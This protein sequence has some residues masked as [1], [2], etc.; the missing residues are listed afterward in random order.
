MVQ[1]GSGQ[2]CAHQTG[3]GLRS[4]QVPAGFGSSKVLFTVTWTTLQCSPFIS[5]GCSMLGCCKGAC[6]RYQCQLIV[7]LPMETRRVNQLEAPL[8]CCLTCHVSYG[9]SSRY[10]GIQEMAVRIFL[11]NTCKDLSLFAIIHKNLLGTLQGHDR[12]EHN[13]VMTKLTSGGCHVVALRQR[14]HRNVWAGASV[15]VEQA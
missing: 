11:C 8:Q 10:C 7:C 15:K 5:T 13:L 1:L 4:D 3:L 14:V 12:P 2:R 9:V 6:A